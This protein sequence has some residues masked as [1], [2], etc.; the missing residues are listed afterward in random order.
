MVYQL[1]QSLQEIPG[2][3]VGRY[4]MQQHSNVEAQPSCQ[5]YIDGSILVEIL[6][7]LLNEIRFGIMGF[8]RLVKDIRVLAKR[9]VTDMQSNAYLFEVQPSS[10]LCF[11]SK[12]SPTWRNIML[13]NAVLVQ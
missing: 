2:I 11:D 4:E 1:A 12:S 8:L 9:L 10:S 3:G 7:S 6:R 5:K 13:P